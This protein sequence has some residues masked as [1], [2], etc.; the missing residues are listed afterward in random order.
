MD[1][2]SSKALWRAGIGGAWTI[3]WTKTRIKDAVSAESV[4]ESE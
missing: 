3:R 2:P 4:C 1:P